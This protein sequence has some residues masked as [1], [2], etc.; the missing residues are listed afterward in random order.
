MTTILEEDYARSQ[1][2]PRKRKGLAFLP[3]RFKKPLMAPKGVQ[4]LALRSIPF[5]KSY[6][7]P[8][9]CPHC[10]KNHKGDVHWRITG[11]YL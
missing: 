11:T 7:G 3:S 2:I 9:I 1:G 5:K 8:P 6:V 10:G 4:Q